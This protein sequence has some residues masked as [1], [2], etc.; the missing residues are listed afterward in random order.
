MDILGQIKKEEDALQRQRKENKNKYTAEIRSLEATLKE[1]KAN[2]DA[3]SI[4]AK[5]TADTLI[6]EAQE[7]LATSKKAFDDSEKTKGEN[8]QL[9]KKL[10]SELAKIE[11][12]KKE[13][14]DWRASEQLKIEE[15]QALA[16]WKTDEAMSILNDAE[17]QRSQVSAIKDALITAR[18]E[19]DLEKEDIQK[20]IAE[21][22]EVQ[23]LTQKIIEEKKAIV[24]KIQSNTENIVSAINEKEKLARAITEKEN[25]VLEIAKENEKESARLRGEKEKIE[26]HYGEI[27]ALKKEINEKKD[28]LDRQLKEIQQKQRRP[29]HA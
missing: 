19:I 18:E 28:A 25:A 11:K 24:T 20:R 16:A 14:E 3:Q 2:V 5:Q 1:L 8:E 29:N 10:K 17:N 22:Q 12:I 23:A 26:Y 27:D 4:K 6:R 9:N 15:S 21:L 7:N 13:T